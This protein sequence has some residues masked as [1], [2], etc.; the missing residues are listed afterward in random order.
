M[1]KILI[2]VIFLVSII[3]TSCTGAQDTA[4]AESF[5]TGF[6][7]AVKENK[8]EEIFAD[9]PFL[10]SMNKEQQDAT[11]ILFKSLS[12]SGYRL[13]TTFVGHGT[14]NVNVYIPGSSGKAST[15]TIGCEKDKNGKWT[16][17]QNFQQT[18]KI[19]RISL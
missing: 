9:A 5:F 1:K 19:D 18:V 7:S 12:S 17:L 14:Y 6:L 16:M 8:T 11:L 15:Y 10:N 3:V 2:L 4:K 13:T